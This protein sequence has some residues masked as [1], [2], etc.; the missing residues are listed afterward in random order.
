[1]IDTTSQSIVNRVLT[2]RWLDAANCLFN[3]GV[4]VWAVRIPEPLGFFGYLFVALFG[5]WTMWHVSVLA[6]RVLEERK[7]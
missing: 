3:V 1:M 4:F 2:S 7:P 6:Y 5:M